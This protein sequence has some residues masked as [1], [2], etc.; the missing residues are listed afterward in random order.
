[1]KTRNSINSIFGATVLKMTVKNIAPENGVII[2]KFWFG[3]HDG[4]F[5]LFDLGERASTGIR[6]LAE[7]A[8]PRA[9]SRDFEK[10]QSGL[11]QATVL[12]SLPPFGDTAPGQEIS[13]TF[14]FNRQQ[15]NLWF[16]YAA[17]VIPSND[18]FVANKGRKAY[19]VFD[20]EG[21]FKPLD[22]K[23]LGS[24][25][26]D[27]GTERNDELEGNAAGVGNPQLFKPATGKKERGI[28]KVHPGYVRDGNVLGNSMFANADFA[29]PEYQVA[30]ISV[31]E[32][33][34]P[35]SGCILFM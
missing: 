33:P 24:E 22:F 29:Q 16:S 31:Q 27:A 4:S 34:T 3:L 5:D 13:I 12:G 18:A 10:S 14:A 23:V 28:I 17:M 7:D 26:W 2:S 9:L 25:V 15:R 30:Q 19:Q 21:Q 32:V 35:S 1:M 20:S 11:L 6:N 8:D